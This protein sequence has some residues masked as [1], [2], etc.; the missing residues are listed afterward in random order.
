MSTDVRP[1]SQQ[2]EIVLMLNEDLLKEFT[3]E[4]FVML[5]I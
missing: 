3:H 2:A 4:R 1:K 5:I